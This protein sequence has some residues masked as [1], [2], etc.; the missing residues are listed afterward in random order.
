MNPL[1]IVKSYF[2]R[3][4][5][6]VLWRPEQ[7]DDKGPQEKGWV[8]RATKLEDYD[9]AKHR[10]GLI[11]GQEIAPGKFLHDVD[12]DWSPGAK[13][14][15]QFIP[16]TTF[17]YGRKSKTVSHCFYTTPEPIP[18]IQY[19][20]PVDGV[21][22]IE[23]RGVK[24]SG[25]LGF[26][27]MVPP[28]IWSKEGQRE[29]LEFRMPQ[30]DPLH[31]E[32]EVLKV[33]VRLGA[34]GMLFARHFGTNGFGHDPRLAW[35]G[36]LLRA[37][38]EVEDLIKMGES[39]SI[40]CNNRE[41]ADVRRVVESTAQ[42]LEGKSKHVKGGPSLI[43]ILGPEKGKAIVAAVTKWMG[44]DSDFVRTRNGE[45]LKDH[46]QN[47]QRALSILGVELSYNMFSEKIL[48]TEGERTWAVDDFT[49]K[50]LWLRM[51]RDLR[52]RPTFGFFEIVMECLARDNSFHPVRDYL[53]GLKW[54]E[55]PRID[56][57]L[58]EYGGAVESESES[59]EEQTFLEAVSS[60]VL[61][62]AVRRVRKPGCKY[63]EMLVLESQQGMN[64]STALRT[65]CP[66]DQWFSDDLPL[67]VDAKQ[68]I[69]RTLGKWIIEASD[70]VGGRK[71]DR[72]HLKSMLSRQI[73][74]P[75][76]MAYA[77]QPVERARQ[78]IIIG[79]TNTA[80]YLADSTGARRFWPVRVRAFDISA[81]RRDRD[82]LWA[83]AA[84]RE[85]QGESIRLPERLWDKAGEHQDERSEV[86]AW[87]DAIRILIDKT[88]MEV[89]GYK[90][91]LTDDL[92]GALNVPIERRDRMGQRRISEIM[93]RLGFKRTRLRDDEGHPKVGYIQHTKGAITLE[94]PTAVHPDD[95]PD[96]P[97]TDDIPF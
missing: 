57:W 82:Q 49:V 34:I 22:L 84:Q 81:L 62:A 33:R 13:I 97:L 21:T 6:V 88:E 46:Q 51:D 38:I 56:R 39:I 66:D 75:A 64:K 43:K 80:E 10:V 67:N 2:D 52:F 94:P 54:D 76:R 73:D 25:E 17:I 91:V 3:N 24:E 12:I 11:T 96:L 1:E 37:G 72:D 93:Q 14:A 50:S 95:E 89:A 47:I 68:I 90:R 86:D 15:F 44:R 28:S 70:L 26:Q 92:W 19:K 32:T 87:E 59:T 79:T 4:Y 5:R 27:S 69:E 42:A 65:M 31:V 29:T 63:D 8:T 41:I 40:Y 48:I 77:H 61:I 74:G 45:I 35:A 20:D 7:E 83:E 53:N 23:L 60:I 71:A 18:T 58:L 36:F 16:G 55:K 30:F 85:S 9:P 78:F